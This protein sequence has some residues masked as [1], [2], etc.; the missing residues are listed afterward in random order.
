M[1]HPVEKDEPVYGFSGA[2]FS[3]GD[4]SFLGVADFG[5]DFGAAFGGGVPFA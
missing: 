3:A 1:G 2:L 4:A 5:V